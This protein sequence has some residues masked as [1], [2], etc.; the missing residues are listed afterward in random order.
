LQT[1][2]QQHEGSNRGVGQS[3]VMTMSAQEISQHPLVLKM[4]ERLEA[5]EG[6]H[7][8]AIVSIDDTVVQKETSHVAQVEVE[9][10]TRQTSSTQFQV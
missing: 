8:S 10:T 6:Q 3:L 2:F 5:L 1:E 9:D 7:K 4:M